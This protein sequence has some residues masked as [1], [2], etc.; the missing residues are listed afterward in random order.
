[1]RTRCLAL[2]E[3][4]EGL[5]HGAP[6]WFVRRR[7]S[8]AEFV[9]PKEHPRLEE[10]N[11]AL[12]AAAPPGARRELVDEDSTRYFKPRFGGYDWVGMRL[13]VDPDEPAW[14]EWLRSSPT[15][16]ATSHR[17]VSWPSWMPRKIDRPRGIDVG[18][19]QQR[20]RL[21]VSHLSAIDGENA[22][23]ACPGPPAIRRS[24]TAR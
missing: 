10:A 2:P 6:T 7:R 22:A 3:V 4:T 1:M 17:S 21:R 12:W 19:D 20:P 18:K 13:D 8:F 23:A 11:V 9:D 24:R 5:T 16:T 15:P 14:D